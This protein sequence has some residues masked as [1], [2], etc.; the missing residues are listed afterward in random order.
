MIRFAFRW[1]FPAVGLAFVTIGLVGAPGRGDPPLATL[2]GGRTETVVT[3]ARIIEGDPRSTWPRTEIRV[4]WPPGGMDESPVGGL[5]V[6]ARPQW[7]ARLDAEIARHPIGARI[8]VR[9]AHQ[10]PWADRTDIFALAWTVGAV[11]LGGL[12]AAAGML[13]NRVLR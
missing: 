4:A 7:R 13:A 6:S 12:V 8:T 1:L 9:I 10:R 5:S 3:A 11:V 2:W